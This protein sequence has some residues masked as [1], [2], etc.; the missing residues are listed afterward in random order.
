MFALVFVDRLPRCVAAW[1][2]RRLYRHLRR[3]DALVLGSG[4]SGIS[5]FQPQQEFSPGG[6]GVCC[7]Q[8]LPPPEMLEPKSDLRAAGRCLLLLTKQERAGLRST[9][10]ESETA[11]PSWPSL[12]RACKPRRLLYRLT[13][14]RD[15][16]SQ[17]PRAS[18]RFP[19]ANVSLG[20]EGPRG[21]DPWFPRSRYDSVTYA[22]ANSALRPRGAPPRGPRGGNG[23]R[24]PASGCRRAQGRAR[25]PRPASVIARV[26]S[27]AR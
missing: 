4:V 20:G 23:P 19:P 2:V 27:P 22:A 24:H 8:D 11:R 10:R 26:P 3:P 17:H 5:V 15:A 13:S 16:C 7:P 1:P 14:R 21:A 25:G 12:S 9:N 18:E 6:S